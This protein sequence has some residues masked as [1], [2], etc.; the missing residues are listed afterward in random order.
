MAQHVTD[1]IGASV[2]PNGQTKPSPLVHTNSMFDTCLFNMM[3]TL[4]YLDYYSFMALS[5]ISPLITHFGRMIVKCRDYDFSWIAHEDPNWKG[6]HTVPP[7]HA[8]AMLAALIFY[9]MHA[10]DVMR[11]LGGTYT[12]AYRF[13]QG[14]VATLQKYDIDPFLITQVSGASGY[15]SSRTTHLLTRLYSMS[16]PLQWAAQITLLLRP[17]ARTSY[18]TGGKATTPLL[19]NTSP[20]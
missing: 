3:L 10:P 17:A 15:Y 18:F 9:R 4:G 8:R 14:T 6:Q 1:T 16:G 13:G 2:G 5:A 20:K 19:P 12:G 7:T 11:F